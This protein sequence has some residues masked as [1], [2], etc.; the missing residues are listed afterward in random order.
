MIRGLTYLFI[1]LPTLF[2]LGPVALKI[3]MASC[4]HCGS[5]LTLP[6]TFEESAVITKILGYPRPPR[7]TARTCHFFKRPNTTLDSRSVPEPTI[8][9]GFPHPTVSPSLPTWAGEAILERLNFL[10]PIYHMPFSCLG[11]NIHDLRSF[12]ICF[13]PYFAQVAYQ[14][15]RGFYVEVGLLHH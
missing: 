6:A 10:V 14:T 1:K 8:S 15:E 9:L 12:E 11:P 13:T 2:L 5:P 4:P 3:D 7:T